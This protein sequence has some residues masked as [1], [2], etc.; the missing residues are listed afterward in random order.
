MPGIDAS[1]RLWLLSHLL[2]AALDVLPGADWV[3]M[4]RWHTPLLVAVLRRCEHMWHADDT[5]SSVW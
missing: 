4:V 5:S 2:P 1:A 3:R